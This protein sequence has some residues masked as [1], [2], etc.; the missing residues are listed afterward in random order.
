MVDQTLPEITAVHEKNKARR[1]YYRLEQDFKKWLKE[2][3]V[4]FEKAIALGHPKV[5]A[6]QFN[7]KQKRIKDE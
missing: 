6:Y 3:P 5:V 1:Y 7:L 4:E 2:C